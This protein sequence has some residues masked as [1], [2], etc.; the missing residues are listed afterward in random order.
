MTT[1]TNREA[2][3]EIAREA[4]SEAREAGNHETDALVIALDAALAAQRDEPGG[5]EDG[6]TA[7]NGGECPLEEFTRVHV[8]L[9]SGD[10]HRD[11]WARNWDWDHGETCDHIIA[12]RL[13]A[14]GGRES[15][16]GK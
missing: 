6:W 2:L 16:D 5:V 12:Y 3:H 11:S 8:R 15:T 7:W 1:D 10:E 13:A 9:R 4:Y 14:H